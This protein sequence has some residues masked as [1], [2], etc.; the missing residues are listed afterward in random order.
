M[1]PCSPR[2]TARTASPP[3]ARGTSGCSTALSPSTATARR[4]C[5]RCRG[6]PRSRATHRPPARPR[7]RGGGGHR[8]HRRR[9]VDGRRLRPPQERGLSRG[10]DGR[11]RARPR[12]L[13]RGTSS[14]LI[15][16][17]CAAF[18]AAG[19]KT[20]ASALIRCPTCSPARG[21]RPRPRSR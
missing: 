13:P 15:A 10:R 7:P 2:C 1:T 21:C 11:P 3:S 8:H 5:S 19:R 4:R 9:C 12:P 18:G 17:V 6:G 20:G 16:G 14:A